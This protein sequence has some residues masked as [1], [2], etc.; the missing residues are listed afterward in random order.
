MLQ[1]LWEYIN[2]PDVDALSR[3]RNLSF[4]VMAQD[5][6]QKLKSPRGK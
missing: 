2:T 6:A 1:R 5:R 3:K 4:D